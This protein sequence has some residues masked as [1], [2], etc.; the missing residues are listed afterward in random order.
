VGRNNSP[1]FKHGVSANKYFDYMLAG[2]PILDSNNYIKD[3]V[4]LSGCGLIVTPDS[5]QSIRDGILE[6][7]NFGRIK[8]EELGLKGKKY[9]G[10]FH[11]I[12][13]LSN[14]YVKLFDEFL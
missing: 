7:Y 1:L 6:M 5:A 13:F 12:T 3:P 9:V 8:L 2:K 10:E 11:N 14:E 4:E